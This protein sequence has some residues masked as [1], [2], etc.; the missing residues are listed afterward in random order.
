MNRRNFLRVLGLGAV[1]VSTGSLL[2]TQPKIVKLNQNSTSG[3][4]M[5][6]GTDLVVRHI[7]GKCEVVRFTHLYIV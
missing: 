6:P 7:R 2:T 4:R 5:T 1:A 3:A